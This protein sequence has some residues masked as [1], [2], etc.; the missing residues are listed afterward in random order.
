LVSLR[1]VTKV[2]PRW[3]EHMLWLDE[4]VQ[5]AYH[6]MMVCSTKR[7]I[8][9]M[10]WDERGEHKVRQS[11]AIKAKTHRGPELVVVSGGSGWLR[12]DPG[13]VGLAGLVWPVG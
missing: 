2:V 5:D 9:E 8:E 10:G 4:L 7:L 13:L 11:E 12:L 6:G 3:L 1:Q